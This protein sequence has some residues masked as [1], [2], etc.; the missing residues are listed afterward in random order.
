MLRLVFG[1]ELNLNFSTERQLTVARE[2]RKH[3]EMKTLQT[4][5][6]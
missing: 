6:L 4:L 3:D 5:S 2:V 1:A